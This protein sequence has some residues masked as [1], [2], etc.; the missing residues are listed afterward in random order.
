[1]RRCESRRRTGIE[2][3]RFIFDREG[4]TLLTAV[5][6]MG[7]GYYPAMLGTWKRIAP[8]PNAASW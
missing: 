7:P 1:V 4:S 2:V 6:D 5:V 8:F 3:D